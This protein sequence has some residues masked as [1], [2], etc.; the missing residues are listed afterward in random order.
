MGSNLLTY[1]FGER[2]DHEETYIHLQSSK[3][4]LSK[5]SHCERKPVS[6]SGTKIGWMRRHKV[7]NIFSSG[8]LLDLKTGEVD[9][10][11]YKDIYYVVVVDC[12][13][14]GSRV[15]AY[16][17]VLPKGTRRVGKY[18]VWISHQSSYGPPHIVPC[19]FYHLHAWGFIGGYKWRR[20][21]F[22]N[23]LI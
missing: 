15:H 16:K 18:I 7:A 22:W 4:A 23:A 19:V 14:S 8:M 12:G 1:I 21:K 3:F 9:S 10:K 5:S 2:K 20:Q 13:S 6:S 17:F 11:N